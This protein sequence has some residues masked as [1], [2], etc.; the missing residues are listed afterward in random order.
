MAFLC[1]ILYVHWNREQEG[2]S[3]ISRLLIGSKFHIRDESQVQSIPLRFVTNK[4]L[5]H[6]SYQH[7]Y[8]VVCM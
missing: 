2:G 4:K 8:I 5:N 1:S 3:A 6:I 7:L